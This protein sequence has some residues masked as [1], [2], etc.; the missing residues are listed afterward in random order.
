VWFVSMFGLRQAV[1]ITLLL[2]LVSGAAVVVLVPMWEER[3]VLNPVPLPVGDNECEIV[4]LYAATSATPWERFVTGAKQ[5]VKRLNERSGIPSVEVDDAGA[6]PRETATTPQFAIKL[7]GGKRLVFRWYKLT[8][9]SPTSQWVEA[10]MQRRPAPLAII[11]GSSSDLAI[12]LAKSLREQTDKHPEISPP[13]MLLTAATAER[14]FS[15]NNMDAQFIN[16]IH[17][18]RTF[19]FC[20]TNR[21]MAEA[22]TD[23]IWWRPELVPDAGPVYVTMWRD[24][25]YSLDLTDRFFDVLKKRQSSDVGAIENLPI[26]EY[27][28]YSV[29]P[30]D[31]P[32]R[33]EEPVVRQLMETKLSE[34]NIDQKKPLLILPGASN[35]PMRRFLR[36]LMRTAPDAARQFVVATG[37]GLSFNAVYRDRNVLWPIQDLPFNLVLFCHRNPI[38]PSAGFQPEDSP[39]NANPNSGSPTMGTEDLLLN[40]DI[41]EALTLAAQQGGSLPTDGDDLARRLKKARWQMDHIVYEGD[42]PLLF[43]D[44]GN[45]TGGTGE[46]VVWIQPQVEGGRVQA[47]SK[48]A[49]FTPGP[50]WQAVGLPLIVDYDPSKTGHY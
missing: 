28:D 21:Q 5:A 37:D 39:S 43:D 36:G 20:F 24:D 49:V 9:N 41:I 12:D 1:L 3:R 22:V 18:G 46:H 19:R 34:Q 47:K 27:V 50:P 33:W 13:T 25:A 16:E 48:I 14:S 4:W 45:R 32:N 42:Y 6:F 11:G 26:P 15:S 7:N 31:Q 8:S 29:G 44:K 10:L 2:A 17:A 38:D 30:F 35:Q 23:F 40:H